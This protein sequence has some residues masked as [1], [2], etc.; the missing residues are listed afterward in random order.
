MNK[1]NFQRA[2]AILFWLL[3]WQTAAFLFHNS[4]LFVGPLDMLRSLFLQMGTFEFWLSLANSMAKIMGGFLCAFA[5]STLLAGLAFR[6]RWLA[7]LLE[8]VI[9]LQKS[10]PVASFVVLLLILM[11]S[12]SLSVAIVF[13]M[14]FPILYINMSEGLAHVEPQMLEMAKIFHMRPLHRFL[15]IYRPAFLPF[16]ISGSR[17][18]LGM[19]WKSGVAAEII[20][21]PS[22]SIG[23][24]LYLSKIYLDTES[25]FAWTLVIILISLAFE[26]LFLAL[27]K[28]AGKQ[29]FFFSFPASGS[30]SA[31]PG[32]EH[33][34]I[35]LKAL[36][37]SYDSHV[38][39]QDLTLSLKEGEIYA[40]MGPS[41]Q[42][43]TTLL[44]II[45]G[46]VQP[47]CW[48]PEGLQGKKISAVFQEDRLCGP[49][50]AEEN[51]RIVCNC[52]NLQDILA[53]ILP[54]ESLTQETDTYSGGMKRR[55]AIA[56]AILADSDLIIMDEPFTGLDEATKENVI[57]FINK[58]RRNRT[59]LFTT[60]DPEDVRALHAQLINIR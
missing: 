36:S 14:A 60:H 29:K 9:L 40:L 33:T 20:G 17:I 50:T 42:G 44:H 32:A 46:L 53:E 59:L 43:K 12:S 18:A 37:K 28:A 16:L 49:L 38:L 39:F 48:S 51:I 52:P 2:G 41:G 21:V 31:D 5:A 22:H 47:D 19:S 58:Y 10:V 1:K 45:M 23:E 4:I 34:G 7:V 57:A 27:L 13:L 11:G 30:A 55:T 35:T 26:K 3:L 54:S 56:R 8:P 25:L 24:R 15:Y 6:F